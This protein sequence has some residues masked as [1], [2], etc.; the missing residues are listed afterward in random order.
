M[1]PFYNRTF[2]H[3][4]KQ[5][6]EEIGVSC[7]TFGVSGFPLAFL[8]TLDPVARQPKS[9]EQLLK[10]LRD[11]ANV[12]HASKATAEKIHSNQSTSFLLYF[13]S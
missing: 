8:R 7:T 2:A 11:N 12:F 9:S 4:L 3:H 1:T 13:I 10:T 5:S 6:L